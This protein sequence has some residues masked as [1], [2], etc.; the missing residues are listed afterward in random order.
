MVFIKQYPEISA[1][2]IRELANKSTS[3]RSYERYLAIALILE[4]KKADEVS[5]LT[6]RSYKTI[7]NWVTIYNDEGIDE[8]AYNA[9]PG[10]KSFLSND[11]FEAMKLVVQKSPKEVGIDSNQWTYKELIQFI[12]REFNDTVKERTAQKYF[13]KMGFVRKK[14][15]QQYARSSYEKKE[16]SMNM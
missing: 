4:G 2:K 7:L 16:N 10:N 13:N 8:L 9:P 14:P 12:Q 1:S 6:G 5:K 15:K 3:R 11:Q